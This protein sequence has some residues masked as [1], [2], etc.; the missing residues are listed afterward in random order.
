M[1]FKTKYLG[2][3]GVIFFIYLLTKIRFEEIL[4]AIKQI[5]PLWIIPIFIFAILTILINAIRWKYI[6][7][8][9][10]IP[11]S[12]KDAFS[13]TLKALFAENSPGKMGEILVRATYLKKKTKI[14]FGKALFSTT[15][16]RFVDLW[17]TAME[18]VI[19]VLI[20]V[21]LFGLKVSAIIPTLIVLIFIIIAFIVLKKESII[22]KLLKPIYKFIIPSSKRENFSNGF[23]DFYSGFKNIEV[24]V[25]VVSFIY[26]I[27]GV[28]TM[29]L[30]LYFTGLAL[31]ISFPLY[32]AILVEPLMTIAVALPI[33]FS[34]LGAREGVFAYL[35]S[36]ISLSLEKAFVFSITVFIVRNL[37]S[38]VGVILIFFEKRAKIGA[39]Y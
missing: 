6:T 20:L 24:R 10:G 16:S 33:S 25:I 39:C 3:L 1:R 14:G 35:F 7:N 26:D 30:S 37:L 17:V 12:T 13:M 9:L 27:I 2:F 15:F 34:G 23:E 19:A 11:L 31:G 5:D 22:R 36:L 28:G 21:F 38:L 4:N 8:K 32:L 29:A 18:A